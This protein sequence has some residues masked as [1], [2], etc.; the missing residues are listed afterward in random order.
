MIGFLPSGHQIIGQS[1]YDEKKIL[2]DVGDTEIGE[3]N[4]ALAHE[5]GHAT[6]HR[7]NYACD[8]FAT[9]VHSSKRNE[10][11][12]NADPRKLT[13]EREAHMFAAELLMPRKSVIRYFRIIFGRDNLWS[14]ATRTREIIDRGGYKTKDLDLKSVAKLL[15]REPALDGG[16]TL[17]DFFGVSNEAM[18]VRLVRLGLVY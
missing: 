11:L 9:R 7:I 13:L 1:N 3:R 10:K 5:I 14:E 4:F 17:C 6:L 16:K 2:I 12:I 15:A 18:A 8:A